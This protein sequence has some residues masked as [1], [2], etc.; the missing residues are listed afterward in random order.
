MLPN[1]FFDNIDRKYN[2][3]GKIPLPKGGVNEVYGF[4][5]L[6]EERQIKNAAEDLIE[7]YNGKSLTDVTESHDIGWIGSEAIRRQR[8]HLTGSVF[9]KSTGDIIKPYSEEYPTEIF[10]AVENFPLFDNDSKYNLSEYDMKV[11][12][13]AAKPYMD[14]KLIDEETLFACIPKT[15]HKEFSKHQKMKQDG[16]LIGK[17]IL[18]YI[19]YSMNASEDVLKVKNLFSGKKYQGKKFLFELDGFSSICKSIDLSNLP[20]FL[21]YLKSCG[22]GKDYLKMGVEETLIRDINSK[23]EKD[24]SIWYYPYIQIPIISQRSI[25]KR[26]K[27]IYVDKENLSAF[28][29]KMDIIEHSFPF[30]SSGAIFY[31][32]ISGKEVDRVYADSYFDANNKSSHEPQCKKRIVRTIDLSQGT[33]QV[34]LYAQKIIP[35][36]DREYHAEKVDYWN[37]NVKRWALIGGAIGALPGIYEGQPWVYLSAA[38]GAIISGGSIKIISYSSNYEAQEKIRIKVNEEVQRDLN[39]WQDALKK[40]EE[41]I[42]YSVI[43]NKKKII[44]ALEAPSQYYANCNEE[45]IWSDQKSKNPEYSY[46]DL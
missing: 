7:S 5:P 12:S 19:P 45:E 40:E 24:E 28:N 21:W 15:P 25:D 18:N 17:A 27:V 6:V 33:P 2:Y 44:T 26:Q 36:P 41:K 29:F 11:I 14:L 38:L 10:K 20:E 3:D 31:D 13:E 16:Y 9:F 8:K 37:P 30:E 32:G 4:L 39:E 22:G 23:P 34:D 43:Q 1:E 35:R 42:D 46:I